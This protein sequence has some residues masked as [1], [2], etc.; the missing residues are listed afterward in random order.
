MDS[1]WSGGGSRTVACVICRRRSALQLRNFV[2]QYLVGLEVVALPS[3]FGLPGFHVADFAPLAL[4]GPRRRNI[5]FPALRRRIRTRRRRASF[6]SFLSRHLLCNDAAVENKR[7]HDCGCKG[8]FFSGWL[9]NRPLR[10]RRPLCKDLEYGPRKIELLFSRRL[11][12]SRPFV[13]GRP[14]GRLFCNGLLELL[15]LRLFGD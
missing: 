10:R 12:H 3:A 15:A 13:W 7:V 6:P 5:V 8:L 4:F 9:L 2:P 14:F 1:V 11:L